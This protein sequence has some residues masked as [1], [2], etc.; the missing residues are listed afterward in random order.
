MAF[1][2]TI[3]EYA[4]EP[5]IVYTAG[6]AGE[7]QVSPYSGVRVMADYSMLSNRDIYRYTQHMT[8]GDN[9]LLRDTALVTGKYGFVNLSADYVFD[10]GTLL[11]L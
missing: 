2:F 1:V 8:V 5:Y 11:H 6:I 4:G 3:K 10:L 9:I 7:M